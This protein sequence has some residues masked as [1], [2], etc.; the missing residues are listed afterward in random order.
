M[1][2][3]SVFS[4]TQF[5]I[6]SFGER[7]RKR[8]IHLG[9]KLLN[10]WISRGLCVCRFQYAMFRKNVGSVPLKYF[11]EFYSLGLIV[12]AQSQ[13]KEFITNCVSATQ[14]G[15]SRVSIEV[16]WVVSVKRPWAVRTPVCY[17]PAP[18]SY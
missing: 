5:I 18:V 17:L 7:K 12:L 3:P 9:I 16:E 1:G 8:K 11:C 4:C 10:N 13:L 14:E 2:I 6:V 15:V